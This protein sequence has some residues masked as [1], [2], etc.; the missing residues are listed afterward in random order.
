ML[1]SE[2]RCRVKLAIP[3]HLLKFAVVGRDF[4]KR[5]SG[6]QIPYKPEASRSHSQTL[7]HQTN[8]RIKLCPSHF[9]ST[10]Q[11][12]AEYQHPLLLR[13]FHENRTADGR[14]QRLA[15]DFIIPSGATQYRGRSEM[16]HRQQLVGSIMVMKHAR[17]HGIGAGRG[18]R[19][20]NPMC[21]FSSL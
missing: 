12:Q 5:D 1:R 8:N 7:Q 9:R 15:N 16:G 20:M 17:V 14:G 11:T 2:H 4:R 21:E 18:K 3:S 19:Y 13:A 6:I 10:S